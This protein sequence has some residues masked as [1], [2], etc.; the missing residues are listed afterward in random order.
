MSFAGSYLVI[1]PFN[2][3]SEG[4][5]RKIDGDDRALL[6]RKLDKIDNN[7]NLGIIIRTNGKE[8]DLEHL[9]DDYDNLAK[10]W[11]DVQAASCKNHSPCLIHREGDVIYRCLRDFRRNLSKIIVDNAEIYNALKSQLALVWKQEQ[12][13]NIILHQSSVPLYVHYQVEEQIE[14]LFNREQKLQSGGVLT[15]DKTEALTA[16]IDVNSAKSTKGSN[17]EETAVSTNLE[18]VDEVTRVLRL[19][20]IGG[21]IVIDFI[22]MIEKSNRDKVYQHMVKKL[23]NDRAKVY[24]QPISKF[25]LMEI[26]RQKVGASFMD[27]SREI[28][29]SCNG[30]GYT[31][32]TS[33]FARFLLRSIVENSIHGQ[34]EQ[35]QLQTS[36]LVATYMLN[37][38][39]EQ[40]IAIEKQNNVQ[41]IVIANPNFKDNKHQIKRIK[42]VPVSDKNKES[43]DIVPEEAKTDSFEFKRSDKITSRP[44]LTNKRNVKQPEKPGLIKRLIDNLFS[45]TDPDSATQGQ[46][47]KSKATNSRGTQAKSD[48]NKNRRHKHSSYN[49]RKRHNR[50]HQDKF[51]NKNKVDKPQQ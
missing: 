9:Q 34:A 16:V 5:S 35:I 19:M 1:K 45:S 11:E 24:L 13:D 20:D 33:S 30:T 2:T 10:Y 48:V 42:A 27:Q 47:T 31:R 39:R 6:K 28:C 37:E 4:I 32:K 21:L 7:K 23:A 14:A 18:A 26:S 51:R 41:I 43:I 40:I 25:G 44:I 22:D 15:I 8:V 17:I 36:I 29:Q 3:N 38:L 12:L 50:P 49:P 46:A